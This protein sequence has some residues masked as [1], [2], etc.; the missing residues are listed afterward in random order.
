MAEDYDSDFVEQ[1]LDNGNSIELVVDT[2]DEGVSDVVLLVDDGTTGNTPST[3]DLETDVYRTDPNSADW[4][5][6]ADVAGTTA[7]SWTD[8]AYSQKMRYTITNQSGGTDTYRAVL[9]AF[10]GDS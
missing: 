3:Y 9:V 7:R 5:Y 6:Y 10:Q 1:S 8:P 4:F 2:D